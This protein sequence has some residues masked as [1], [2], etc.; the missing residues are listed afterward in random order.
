MILTA[1]QEAEL[2]K[3]RPPVKYPKIGALI[4]AARK[5]KRITQIELAKMLGIEYTEMSYIEHG[6]KL[7]TIEQLKRLA[8]I[9]ET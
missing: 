8:A 2:E 1:E 3:E 9:L 4:H 6:C 5:A 7:P